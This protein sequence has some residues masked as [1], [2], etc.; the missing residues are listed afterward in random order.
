MSGPWDEYAPATAGAAESGPW[1]EYST[2]PAS[3][4]PAAGQQAAAR[5][6]LPKLGQKQTRTDR[7]L[8]GMRDPI[9][10]G[11]QLLVHAL[12]DGLVSSVNKA[13]NWLADKTGLVARLPEGGIDQQVRASNHEY[14]A[15]RKAAG[16]TGIDGY[17]ALGGFIPSGDSYRCHRRRWAQDSGS[18]TG[19]PGGGARCGIWRT[20]AGGGP[21]DY[22][23]EKAKSSRPWAP[24]SRCNACGVRRCCSRHQPER[25]RNPNLALLRKEGVTPT[26]GQALG[27]ISNRIEEKFVSAPLLGDAIRAGRN[28]AD[29]EFQAAAVNRSLAPVGDALPRGVTGRRRS[30][31]PR[32]RCARSMTMC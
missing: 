32:I 25:I 11:A 1:A 5:A 18:P 29:G 6:Q 26:I 27:G 4:A 2:A 19:R 9:D 8:Q 20:G 10:G 15:R 24:A 7:L 13:N 3:P 28:R 22:W 30:R 21:G 16:E 17:R 14:E 12:P 31:M 23:S